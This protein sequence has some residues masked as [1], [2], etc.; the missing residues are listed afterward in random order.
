MAVVSAL[1]GTRS[2][3]GQTSET[4]TAYR[5]GITGKVAYHRPMRRW[6]T[7]RFIALYSL[8]SRISLMNVASRPALFRVCAIS[9]C[10]LIS[11]CT[12]DSRIAGLTRENQSLRENIQL[13]EQQN[14]VMSEELAASRQQVGTLSGLGEERPADLFA[15]VAIEIASLSGGTNM[16]NLPGDDGV[17][18]HLRPVDADGQVVKV[19]GAIAIQLL[20][21]S[22]FAHPRVIA[23]CEV[24]ASDEI[25]KT[26][27]GILGTNH[28]TIRCP[29]PSG[30]AL[31]HSQKITVNASFTDFL[32]GR[33]LTTSKEVLFTP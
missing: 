22:D 31:P 8:Q 26:W 7:I 14:K 1:S 13:L 16:D 2:R 28:Y 12:A 11:A 15:P 18:V 27:M 4:P 25:R 10:L 30:V 3:I 33:V 32:T 5:N 23:L 24:R 17:T 29:F 21:N 9:S 19:P 6:T 20:D